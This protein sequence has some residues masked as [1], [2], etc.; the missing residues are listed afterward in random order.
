M[1]S[2]HRLA[3]MLLA[4]GLL[5]ALA[6][7]VQAPGATFPSAL[8]DPQPNEQARLRVAVSRSLRQADLWLVSQQ[9][10]DGRWQGSEYSDLGLTALAVAALEGSTEAAAVGARRRGQAA[11][12]ALLCTDLTPAGVLRAC[13][14]WRAR[15]TVYELSVSCLALSEPAAQA[16]LP[17]NLAEPVRGASPADRILLGA[18][19]EVLRKG[20]LL[21]GQGVESGW[22]YRVED[23][24]APP[25]W[26]LPT[27]PEA[28]SRINSNLSCTEF[29]ILGL[30]TAQQCGVVS[31]DAFW[32]RAARAVLSY[33]GGGGGFFYLGAMGSTRCT[34]GMT[35][36][37]VWCLEICRRRITGKPEFALAETAIADASQSGGEWVTRRFRPDANPAD[38]GTDAHHLS[39][40]FSLA[41]ACRLHGWQMLNKVAWYES[42]SEWL[43]KQQ[44][45]SGFWGNRSSQDTSLAVLV[46]RVPHSTPDRAAPSVTGK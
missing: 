19:A 28:R 4:V 10:E 46:L 21:P 1:C 42:C 26:R 14:D 8:G 35:C 20:M 41:R 27:E 34:G 17:G 24:T 16:G 29:A 36:A 44:S 31:D 5:L 33:R 3:P 30:H 37:A 22:G 12:R 45:S 15:R 2:P 6:T 43:L 7:G 40:L 23:A 38:K 39:Y 32:A 11:V 9:R 18:L 13:E 25:A